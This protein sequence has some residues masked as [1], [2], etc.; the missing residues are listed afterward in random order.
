MVKKNE[1]VKKEQ[2]PLAVPQAPQLGF[3]G[4]TDQDELVIPRAKLIQAMADEMS[5]KELKAMYKENDFE[6]LGVGSI[7]NSLT[8][9]PVPTE[10]I[11]VFR[12]YEYMKFNPRDQRDPAFDQNHPAG[13]LIWRTNDSNDPRVAETQW[14]ENGEKPTAQKC[15]NFFAYFPAIDMPLII[16]FSKSN[17]NFGRQLLTAL[18][19]SK[20]S[21]F[22]KKFKLT[23]DMKSNDQGTFAVLKVRQTNDPTAEEIAVARQ[24]HADFAMKVKDIKAHEEEVKPEETPW[25]K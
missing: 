15:L 18:R 22:E 2:A 21:M 13:A 25:E 17:Y 8:K 19:L 16:T 7:I 11:P 1:I 24:L 5:D 20:R 12:Y 9:E 4:D 10:F 6:P 14:G 23:S 3:E